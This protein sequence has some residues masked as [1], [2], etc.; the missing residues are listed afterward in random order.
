MENENSKS[1]DLKYGSRWSITG[2]IIV[3]ALFTLINYFPILQ[4]RIPFPRDLV[5][6][7]AAWDGIRPDPG[8]PV[9]ENSDVIS[10]F[11]PFHALASHSS[12][13]DGF[14]LWNPYLLS[15]SPFEANSQSALFYPLNIF[16]FLIP[17]PAAWT[18]ALLLRMFLAACFMALLVRALGGSTSGCIVS[19]MMFASCGF[20]TAWQGSALGDAAIWLPMILY[21]V[22]GLR[23]RMDP[24]SIAIAALSFAMPALAGHP[25]TSAHLAATGSILAIVLC[26]FNVEA[27]ARSLDRRFIGSF[28][29]AGVLALGLASVQI[30]PTLEWMRQLVP[31][32]GVEQAALTRHDGQGF[33]SRDI[34][35][36][37]NSA[38]IPIPEGASYAGML[39]LLAAPFAFFHSSKRYAWVFAAMAIAAIAIAFSVSPVHGFIAHIPIVKAMKNGR[40]ILVASVSLA[41]MAGM[42]ISTLSR[43]RLP[44]GQVLLIAVSIIV[45]LGIVEVYRATQTPPPPFAGPASS[46]VFLIAAFAL[47]TIRLNTRLGNSAFGWLA[48]GLTAVELLSFSF[49]FLGFAKPEEIYP[50]APIFDFLKKQ[51]DPF[52]FR[53]IKTGY[54]VPANSGIMYGIQMAEGYDL[55]TERARLFTE[56]LAETRDDAV[57]FLAENIQRS[58]DRRLD[59]LN[60]KYAVAIFPGPDFDRFAQQPSRFSLVYKERSIAV[61]ENK[62]AMPRV[63][64]VPM[65]GIEVIPDPQTQLKRIKDPAFDAA[66]RV[67]LPH[68]AAENSGAALTS[69]LQPLNAGNNSFSL[70]T[71]T[72]ASSILVLS[73]IYYPG[74]HA[75]IDGIETPV[76]TPDFALCG[77]ALPAGAHEV[78]FFFRPESFIAGAAISVLSLAVICYS[79]LRKRSVAAV[80]VTAANASR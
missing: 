43:T 27:G 48:C 23:R 77:I 30:I 56:G 40:L 54:P 65:D 26:I 33:F 72:S 51:G 62:S 25:E 39:G 60:V 69:K 8:K 17:L 47:L 55:S 76:L 16:Y 12:R 80:M 19:G 14:P 68:A 2:P 28:M 66:H 15:G 35:S 32:V 49:G 67:I 5:L 9:A 1:S 78:K 11:Y 70:R 57:F 13:E 36:G 46:L 44:K 37:P 64:A 6:R 29:L 31:Q 59:L 74:W 53:I 42:G 7:H 75:T 79:V 41:A 21:S 10:T 73:Q 22:I 34:S 71:E 24:R 50:A 61:F 4:G 63:F 38:L 20:I 45:A 18:A 58:P 52:A 3:F